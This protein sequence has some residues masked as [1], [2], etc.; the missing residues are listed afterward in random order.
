M[1]VIGKF[2]TKRTKMMKL[3]G[4]KS[5]IITEKKRLKEKKA[6]AIEFLKPKS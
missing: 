3:K 4:S 6:T 1:K 5:G 2:I